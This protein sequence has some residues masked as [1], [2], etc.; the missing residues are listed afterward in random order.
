MLNS[1]KRGKLHCATALM[2]L[3]TLPDKVAGYHSIRR[4]SLN[5]CLWIHRYIVVDNFVG[6]DLAARLRAEALTLW[7][8]GAWDLC[9]QRFTDVAGF[10]ATS[11]DDHLWM[12]AASRR[13]HALAQDM[14]ETSQV[15]QRRLLLVK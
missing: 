5:E 9:S 10:Q 7:D 12:Q 8:Q 15:L 11:C 13:H 14:E 1:G 6:R 2:C 3:L 4:N